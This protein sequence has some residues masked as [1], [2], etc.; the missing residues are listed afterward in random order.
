MLGK[1]PTCNG[2]SASEYTIWERVKES[3]NS[4]NVSNKIEFIKINDRLSNNPK[5]MTKEFY[6]FFIQIGTSILKKLI[7]LSLNPMILF[8]PTLTHLN[9]G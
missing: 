8:L 7:P 3:N 9:I 4:S 1:L 6:F 2:L 5:E